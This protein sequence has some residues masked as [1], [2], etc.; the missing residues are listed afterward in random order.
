MFFY[1]CQIQ[2]SWFVYHLYFLTACYN[3]MEKYHLDVYC[4]Q[5]QFLHRYQCMKQ[6]EGRRKNIKA[7]VHQRSLL[8]KMLAIVIDDRQIMYSPWPPWVVRH[9]QDH[10]YLCHIAQ[11][12]QGKYRG[13]YYKTFYGSNYCH[14]VINQ[15]VC[16]LH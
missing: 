9:R 1:H 4:F 11:G 10:F 2:H 15:C 14:I 8:V 3:Q 5:S 7:K 12:G 6:I 16:H 13:L